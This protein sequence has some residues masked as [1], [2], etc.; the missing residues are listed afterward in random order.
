MK[1]GNGVDPGELQE[2]SAFL[3]G[4]AI[5]DGK[6]AG[7]R[8]PVSVAKAL[9]LLTPGFFPLWDDKIARGYY[10]HCSR[11][12]S[13]Q[14]IQFMKIIKG[15]VDSLRGR[16]EAR[17]GTLLKVIDEYV[18]DHRETACG[19]IFQMGNCKTICH[20]RKRAL[21]FIMPLS[22]IWF[23]KQLDPDYEH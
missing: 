4:L 3:D 5:S 14:Y 18:N 19:I 13:G 21:M 11:D 20:S 9:H 16:V 15:M 8:S 1:T 17:G 10:C 6:S 22:G 12:P 7:F 23:F 2:G